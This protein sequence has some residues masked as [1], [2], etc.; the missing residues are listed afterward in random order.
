MTTSDPDYQTHPLEH[1]E[2]YALDAL[3]DQEFEEVEAHLEWCG[4]CQA[5]VSTLQR[6][7]SH[8]SLSV[9]FQQP[10]PELRASLSRA[11]GAAPAVTIAAPA[12]ISSRGPWVSAAR[13]LMP[14]AAAVMLGLF[15]LA[16]VMN[17]RLTDRTE[18]LERVNSTLTAQVAQNVEQGSKNLDRLQGLQTS[19]Y[20]L[21]DP[22]NQPVMLSPA[23][24]GGESAR[25]SRGILLVSADGERAVMLVSGMTEG[26]PAT[27][28]EVWLMRQGD[29]TVVGTVTVDDDG[30]GTANLRPGESVY[31][32]DK[33]E[34]VTEVRP[35]TTPTIQHMILQADIPPSK[36]PEMLVHP[37]WQ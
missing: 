37:P 4:Q 14:V 7:T 30:W 24:G 27:T 9:H 35:G 8:L 10:P 15:T 2:G 3:E 11:V 5:T 36:P 32:Y 17:V 13:F 28:Y 1:L 23:G 20:W 29:R 25:G 21:A 19:S 26:Q 34:L 18:T 22:N 12:P 31:A 33:V 6:A 16:M